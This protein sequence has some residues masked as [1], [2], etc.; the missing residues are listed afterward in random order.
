MFIWNFSHCRFHSWR[1]GLLPPCPFSLPSLPL[2][3]SSLLLLFILPPL[4]PL[5][6]LLARV[7]PYLLTFSLTT[8]SFGQIQLPLCVARSIPY[9]PCGGRR[10]RLNTVPL[11]RSRRAFWLYSARA[12]LPVPVLGGRTDMDDVARDNTHWCDMTLNRGVDVHRR[13]TIGRF[14][15]WRDRT[16]S[17]F[18]FLRR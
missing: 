18:A 3:T 5:P 6:A 14:L 10:M 2:P 1:L 7:L 16:C 17:F 4:L 12:G 8:I 11:Y 15:R 13:G 9:T